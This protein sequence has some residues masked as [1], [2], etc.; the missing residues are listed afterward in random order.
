[1]MKKLRAAQTPLALLG[2]LVVS[3]GLLLPTLGIY[4]DDWSVML[5]ATLRGVPG[6]WEYY[7]FDRPFVAWTYAVFLPLLGTTPIVWHIF[8]LLLRWG[9]AWAVWWALLGLWPERRRE[10]TLV[11]FLFAV[12]PI[13]TEQAIAVQYSQQWICYLFYCLSLGLMIAAWRNPR[14]A[15]LFT[16]LGVILST[17]QMFT[18]EYF[19]GIEAL[20]PLILWILASEVDESRIRRARRVGIAW[21]PYVGVLV[22]FVIWRLF[23]LKLP[24]ADPNTPTLLFQLRTAPVSTAL[25]VLQLGL[26][27]MAFMLVS[28]WANLFQAD[29]IQLNDRWVVI[30]WA[31]GAIL[32]AGVYFFM[33]W[34]FARQSDEEHSN[35]SRQAV[36][37]GVAGMVFG[38][39]PIWLTDRQVSAGLYADRF[40]MPAMLGASLLVVG[41]IGWL[42]PSYRR[43]LL[44]VMLLMGAAVGEH[45]RIANDYHWAWVNQ[46]RFY[47]QLAWRAPYIEPHT[48]IFADG[49]ILKYMG[50]NATTA[51]II[52]ANPPSGLPQ[53]EL[54]YY[55][56]SLGREFSW[57]MP[58]F[59]SGMQVTEHNYRIYHFTGNT[60]DA[61]VIDYDLQKNNCLHILTPQDKKAPGLP[62]ITV[63]ALPNAN[64]SRIGD[65][66]RA[67]G[68]P[69]VS[70]FGP[71]PERGW[72]YYYEKADLARQLGDWKQVTQLAE[73]AAQKGF[74][75]KNSASNTPFE[76]LPMIEGYA[77]TNQVEK[78]AQISRDALARDSHMQPRLCDLWKTIRADAPDAAGALIELQCAP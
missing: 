5:T 69:Q 19:V 68:Y 78:A 46:A 64:L 21:L 67:A 38:V 71:E 65:T 54:P 14:R 74:T 61:L 17:V 35:W 12:Y 34:M 39:V 33:R 56:Y 32:A 1:M 9:T 43:R 59:L 66:P 77:R 58:E 27:D 20:R 51:G 50:L 70:L 45:W 76:W 42:T 40:G 37:L 29:T 49:E 55:F 72:C 52:I 53:N 25:H 15:V 57:Q 10:V 36:A 13:F 2:V 63:E 48:P 75:L 4:W 41:L 6:F 60:R 47:W 62:G 22:F 26:Q 8:T 16:G 73:Q 7:S 23:L 24:L 18:M 3:F 30:S 11:A 31:V 28:V 44:L